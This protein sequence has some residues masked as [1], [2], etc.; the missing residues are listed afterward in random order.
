MISIILQRLYQQGI[1]QMILVF[2]AMNKT[3]VKALSTV[4][5]QKYKYPDMAMPTKPVLSR[6]GH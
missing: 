5:K 3:F 2:S 4:Y 6:W 1:L